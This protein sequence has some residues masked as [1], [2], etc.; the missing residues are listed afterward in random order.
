[1]RSESK[2]HSKTTQIDAP[3]T[4]YRMR[5]KIVRYLYNFSSFCQIDQADRFDQLKFL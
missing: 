4:Y 1:M 5:K 2:K 3:S